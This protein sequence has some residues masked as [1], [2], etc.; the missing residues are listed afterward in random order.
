MPEPSV[1]P[2]PEDIPIP[3]ADDLVIKILIDQMIDSDESSTDAL[4]IF[5]ATVGD[6]KR[7]EVNERKMTDG[8][9][10]LF[11][12]AKG[13]RVAAVAGSPSF[14]RCEQECCRQ[15]LE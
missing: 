8:D 3:D 5:A 2:E 10:K 6:Q 1:V 13:G 4:E 14:R 9:R 15:S 12:R 11:R 7:V